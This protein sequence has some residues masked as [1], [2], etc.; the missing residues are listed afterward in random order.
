MRIPSLVCLL[1]VGCG[2]SAMEHVQA[3]RLREACD[4]T[5]YSEHELLL[6]EIESYAEVRVVAHV[7]TD[8]EIEALFGSP[9]GW[10]AD[11]N[12]LVMNAIETARPLS[13]PLVFLAS[14]VTPLPGGLT[15]HYR[16]LPCC[17]D[18]EWAQLATGGPVRPGHR[19]RFERFTEHVGRA[20]RATLGS[21]VQSVSDAL[22]LSTLGAIDLQLGTLRDGVISPRTLLE[23]VG[24]ARSGGT[25][26][27][28]PET[29]P[30]STE[31]L[32]PQVREARAR[33]VLEDL[34]SAHCELPAGETRA[35][36]HRILHRAPGDASRSERFVETTFGMRAPPRPGE[37][38]CSASRVRREP[39]GRDQGTAEAINALLGVPRPP[40]RLP[41]E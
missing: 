8:A 30:E 38:H 33:M 35:V 22:Y 32:S 2:A 13:E 34:T 9:P 1:L 10:P 26:A 39:I 11:H 6:D 25:G 18:D 14:P 7:Y 15:R 41:G 20:L 37:N 23:A 21:G 17:D 5:A 40:S 27:A 3:N 12:F 24:E 4:A 19:S 36:C 16:Q 31:A 28:A 29:G